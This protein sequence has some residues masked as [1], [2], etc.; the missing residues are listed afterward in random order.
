K[1]EVHTPAGVA[2]VVGTDFYVG[3]DNGTMTVIAFEGIVR[4]C[5]LAGVCVLVKAG[6]MSRGRSGG[7]SR[8]LARVQAELLT[9][10]TAVD[11]TNVGGGGGVGLRAGAEQGGVHISKGMGITLGVLAAIPAV[12]VPIASK[13]SNQTTPVPVRCQPPKCG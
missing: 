7:N 9:L 5:N 13:G 4:V 1:F 11:D 12:V 10:T 6:Q 3:F 2:G 8:P